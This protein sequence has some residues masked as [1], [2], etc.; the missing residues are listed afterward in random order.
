MTANACDQQAPD[1]H[2]SV[3]AADLLQQGRKFQPADRLVLRAAAVASPCG[4]SVAAYADGLLLRRA[5]CPAS[6]PAE[7][8][9][10]LQLEAAP[11]TQAS[12]PEA[13]ATTVAA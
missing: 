2:A 12:R 1:P 5:P 7:P 10:P 9:S 4:A 8:F 3:R 6:P 13:L 11:S